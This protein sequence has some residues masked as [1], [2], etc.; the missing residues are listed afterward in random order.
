M[1]AVKFIYLFLAIFFGFSNIVKAFR[2]LAITNTQLFL[3]AIGIV[4]YIY[5]Q[6]WV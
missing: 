1:N 3:M 6:F 2:G 5:F 4:G